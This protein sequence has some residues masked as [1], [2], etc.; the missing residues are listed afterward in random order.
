M[1]MISPGMSS[2][3]FGMFNPGRLAAA[4]SGGIA[5]TPHARHFLSVL[6]VDEFPCRG[7]NGVSCFSGRD[8]PPVADAAG[9]SL[10]DSQ[11]VTGGSSFPRGSDKALEMFMVSEEIPVLA[12][13]PGGSLIFSQ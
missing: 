10:E 13:T 3:R 4:M 9:V 11:R 6:W 2:V 8:R 12:V 1:I 5:L 7:M